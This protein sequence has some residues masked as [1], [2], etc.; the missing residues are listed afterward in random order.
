MGILL[1]EL[2]PSPFEKPERPLDPKTATG[3]VGIPVSNDHVWDVEVLEEIV[4]SREVS[5]CDGTNTYPDFVEGGLQQLGEAGNQELLRLPLDEDHSL[6]KEDFR[7]GDVQ[8]SLDV[9]D[10]TL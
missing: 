10:S 1:A 2:D 3:A 4:V 7:S 8:V 6:R 5:A 9:F